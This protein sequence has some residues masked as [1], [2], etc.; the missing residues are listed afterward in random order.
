MSVNRLRIVEESKVAIPTRSI[1]LPSQLELTLADTYQGTLPVAT[2]YVGHQP[3]SNVS[4]NEGR[5]EYQRI[6]SALQEGRYV[7]ELDSNLRVTFLFPF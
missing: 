3:V 4:R 1:S 7:L 5:A 2:V 6:Q